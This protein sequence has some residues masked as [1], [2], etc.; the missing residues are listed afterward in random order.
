MN[1]DVFLLIVFGSLLGA[2]ILFVV[3]PCF[4]VSYV[5]FRVLLVR[6][7]PEKWSRTVS[8]EDDEQQ[9]MFDEGKAWG[10][11]YEEHRKQVSIVSGKFRLV[12]EYF[13]FGSNKVALIIPGRME[14]GTYS[15][16]FSEPYRAL[17]YNILA[18][19]NRSHGLSDGRYNTVGLR[20]YVDILKWLEFAHD[21]LHN[22]SVIIHGIC[23]GSATAL[24]A[25][26]DKKCPEYVEG[27]VA[28]G[29]YINFKENF[30]NHLIERKK[31]LVPFTQ[32]FMFILTLVAR[33][34][35]ETYSPINQI[36]K[37]NVPLLLI[38]SREDIYSTHQYGQ[39]LFEKAGSKK[40]RIKLFKHGA[41]SH[42]RIN[43][44]EKYDKTIKDFVE[45]VV[46]A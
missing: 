13:D 17:G 30:K 38:Y 44:V 45:E 28:D 34:S 24:N 9:Q 7:S 15:Y 43:D 22:E 14:S 5:I 20:E 10:E 27:L 19:D 11:K 18:I 2:F 16:Y 40:K 37:L 29:M 33:R 39:V 26:V 4:I 12:G 41:H 46:N 25:L 23:I 8:W 21:E 6:T 31:P 42:V 35:P 3:I 32:M 36:G 1:P